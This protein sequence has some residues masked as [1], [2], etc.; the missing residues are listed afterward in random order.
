MAFGIY[1][2]IPYCVKKCP[3]CDF[4]S[5]AL[6]K[7]VPE[8]KY[9][10]ALLKEID[11]NSN[12]IG[13]KE[14][15]TVFFGGGTPSLFSSGSIEKIMNKLLSHCTQ[16]HVIEA[17]VEVNPKTVDSQKL[18]GFRS[19]GINRI[20][21]GV[22]SFAMEKLEFLGRINTAEDSVNTV[23]DTARAGF[24][25]ISIDLMFG[26]PG[27][28]LEGWRS[29]LERAVNLP[30]THISCYCLTVEEGTQFAALQRE[31]SMEL[32]GDDT[33]ASMLQLTKEYLEDAGYRQYEVSN[34]S[35]EG[36]QCLHNVLYWKGQNY[37]GLGAGAHSHIKKDFSDSVDQS[38]WGR[39]WAN[40]KNPDVYIKTLMA[41]GSP[42]VFKE[43]LS[44]QQALEDRIL[45]GLRL[46]EGLNTS[47]IRDEYGAQFDSGAMRY[48]FDDGFLE[49]RKGRLRVTDKGT[50][51]LDGLIMSVVGSAICAP[52]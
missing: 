39:R 38:S 46:R 2:H 34:Y 24:D 13:G 49:Q 37:L 36:R 41:G 51:L 29:D 31:G 25:N 23:H 42:V 28:S 35:L 43:N 5:Y 6:S 44:K 4:N 1:I 48:L 15:D 27:E 19:A 3:Y 50:P 14:L 12:I 17:T 18:L 47:E 20:S 7:L 40:I 21:V 45:M 30:L 9:T 16:G 22:Q 33:A 11:L 52:M 8:E 26:V 32:P 10:E